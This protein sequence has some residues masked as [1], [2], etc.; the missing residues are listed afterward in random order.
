MTTLN[1]QVEF[2][3]DQNEGYRAGIQDAIDHIKKRLA[4]GLDVDP[5][6]MIERLKRLQQIS[7]LGE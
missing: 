6:Y 1:L 4:K 3:H 2:N 7:E 5:L